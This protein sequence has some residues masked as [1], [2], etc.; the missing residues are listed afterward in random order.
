MTLS[1]QLEELYETL[2][3]EHAD[4]PQWKREALRRDEQFFVQ[5]R[6]D[7]SRIF[8]KASS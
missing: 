4:L 7:D 1:P 8:M 3:K 6:D 2:T 5:T